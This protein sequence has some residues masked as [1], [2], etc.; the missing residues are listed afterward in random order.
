MSLNSFSFVS[1]ARRLFRGAA[2]LVVA[3]TLTTA[4]FAQDDAAAA[5]NGRR[6]RRGQNGDPAAGGGFGQNG[7]GRGN[8]DPA[9]MQQQMTDRIREQLGVTDDAEWNLILERVNK[10]QELQRSTPRGGGLAAFGGGGG[11]GRGGRAAG[12]GNA[13]LQ[14]LNQAI[15]DKLPDA[16]IKSRLERLREVRKQSEEALTKAQEDLRAVLSVRQEA[17]AVMAGL[18]P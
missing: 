18:L 8:F 13:E 5:Q 6:G 16:E 15:T 12:Q 14:A 4:A 1:P 7:G 2:V 11:G 10:V 3:T 17:V 9:Q